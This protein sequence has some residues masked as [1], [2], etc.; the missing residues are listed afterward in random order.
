MGEFKVTVNISSLN[1]KRRSASIRLLVDTG[2][3]LAVVPSLVL[4]RL[5]VTPLDTTTVVLADGRE[6][7]RKLGEARFEI[8]GHSAPALVVFGESTDEPVLGVTIL[9]QIRLGVDPVRR[10]LV[11]ARLL[12]V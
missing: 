11:P 1:G 12:Y 4:K 8:E 7:Q 5:G 2:A 9:E 10:R 3:T 6:V